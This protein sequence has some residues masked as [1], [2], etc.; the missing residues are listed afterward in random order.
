MTIAES[1]FG[2]LKAA[3]VLRVPIQ[4][5]YHLNAQQ[6]QIHIISVCDVC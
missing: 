1:L 5:S 4:F 6:Y 3:L 2:Q